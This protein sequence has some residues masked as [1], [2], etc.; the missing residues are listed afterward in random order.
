LGGSERSSL[1]AT[2]TVAAEAVVI[3]WF[4]VISSETRT[5]TD[6]GYNEKAFVRTNPRIT[7]ITFLVRT[8]IYP[9]VLSISET[10]KQKCITNLA[11]SK[12]LR[13]SYNTPIHIT[14]GKGQYL[15]DAE[16]NRYLD[17]YNNVAHGN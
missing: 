14:R 5:E 2:G 1:A 10:H 3:N 12:T 6:V 7:K 8:N 4:P 13:P 11:C 9:S 17:A 15:F 16:G